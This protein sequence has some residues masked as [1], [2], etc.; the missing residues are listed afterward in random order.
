MGW[1]SREIGIATGV[2]A[3]ASASEMGGSD[4]VGFEPL[5]LTMGAFVGVVVGTVSVVGGTLAV[6]SAQVWPPRSAWCWRHRFAV[7]S[8]AAV[9]LLLAMF[10]IWSVSTSGMS[11]NPDSSEGAWFM[12]MS[13]ACAAVTYGCTIFLAPTVDSRA[14]PRRPKRMSDPGTRSSG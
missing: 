3:I 6:Q 14:H 12:G 2:G 1:I 13:A 8:A 7:C 5:V 10:F 9:F 11:T 4:V